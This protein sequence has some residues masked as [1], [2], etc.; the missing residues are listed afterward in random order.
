MP[1][2]N[3]KPRRQTTKNHVPNTDDKSRGKTTKTHGQ[4][5]KTRGQTTN[6]LT[7][8]RYEN[9]IVK[10]YVNFDKT[11]GGPA[12]STGIDDSMLYDQ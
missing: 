4:T 12:G 1:L 3:D 7:Y 2:K 8:N 11:T 6:N 10:S 5:T 9:N